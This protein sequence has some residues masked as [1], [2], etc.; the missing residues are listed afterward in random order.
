MTVQ[1][2]ENQFVEQYNPT[3]ENT[4]HKVIKYGG[5]DFGLEIVDTAGQVSYLII[6][7]TALLVKT[8]DPDEFYGHGTNCLLQ[9]EYSIFQRQ[10]AVGIHGYVLVY[11][12]TSKTSFEM[13]KIINEKILNA[14]GTDKVPRVLVGNKKDLTYER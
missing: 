4:F 6:W 9:D 13:V 11:A 12:V 2:V 1:F 10:Y 5:E 8:S 7:L 3:I 14:L